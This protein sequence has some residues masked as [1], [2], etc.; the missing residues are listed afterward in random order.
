MRIQGL[1]FRV[2]VQDVGFRVSRTGLRI[3][4]RLCFGGPDSE[5]FVVWEDGRLAMTRVLKW[6]YGIL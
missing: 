3:L 2:W 6:K 1:G 5:D 4:E